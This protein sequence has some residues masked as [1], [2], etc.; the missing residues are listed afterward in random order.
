MPLVFIALAFIGMFLVS[1]VAAA[2]SEGLEWGIATGFT[3]DYTM[4]ATA[5]GSFGME[6]DEDL[7]LNVTDMPSAAIPDPLDDW[8]DIPSGFDMAFYWAN[9]TS[10]GL[11]GLVFVYLMAVGEKFVVPIGNWDLL[12]SLLAQEL[13]DEE[14]TS[15]VSLWKVVWSEAQTPTEE[16][17]ITAGYAKADGVL[18]D[19]RIEVVSTLNE[20]VLGSFTC[21]RNNIPLPGGSDIID[22]IMDNILYVGIGVGVIVILGAVVC[23]RRR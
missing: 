21:I 20:T 23:M 14:I 11:Y 10:I 8:N 19:Y 15:E 5:G 9:D 16:L 3:A 2:T 4:T 1:P 7:Y 13:T 17:R 6:M 12:E 18:S 22:L